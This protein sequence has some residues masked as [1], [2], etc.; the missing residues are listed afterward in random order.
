MGVGGIGSTF[1][2]HLARAGGHEVT[3]IARPGSAR[4]GR[5]LTDTGIISITGEHA[6]VSVT[7]T[8]DGAVPYDLVVVTLL[9]HQVD[10]VLLALKRS[11]ARYILFMF[12]NFDPE[13]LRDT[14]G[15][16]R[17]AMAPASL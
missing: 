4:L 6:A 14:I 15:I 13:R 7:D 8:L 3:V 9:A 12:N 2:F 16:E 5:L 1:A 17:R 10:A 11:A